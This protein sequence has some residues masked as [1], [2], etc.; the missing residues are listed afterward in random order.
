MEIERW[1]SGRAYATPAYRRFYENLWLEQHLIFAGFS[2]NDVT[3][4]AIAD[5]MVSKFTY[6]GPPRHIA[7]LA[8]S[9]PCNDGMRRE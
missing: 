9:D 1:L 7:I 8:L 2:F 3:L 5:E 4:T 6:A